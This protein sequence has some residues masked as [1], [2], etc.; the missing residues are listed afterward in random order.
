MFAYCNNNPIHSTDPLGTFS[1]GA[2]AGAVVGGAVAGTLI[3]TVSYAVISGLNGN[4]ITKDGLIDA[5]ISGAVSGAI[6][7]AIGTI[8][9]GAKAVSMVQK[10][11]PSVSEKMLTR[12]AKAIAS[13][14]TGILMSNN[15]T[16]QGIM[17]ASVSTSTFLGSMIDATQAEKSR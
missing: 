15:Q 13:L 14:T 11:I 5:A 7:G 2:F 12:G 1:I 17:L 10:V 9:V 6:G 8:S 4:A 3:S 16:E